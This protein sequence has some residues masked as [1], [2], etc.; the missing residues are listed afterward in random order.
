M[1]IFKSDDGTL[2]TCIED[3]GL[4]S[5]RSLVAYSP[6]KGEL[7]KC[8]LA[9]KD[10][11]LE[12]G[13]WVVNP[14]IAKYLTPAHELLLRSSI[15]TCFSSNYS[16]SVCLP[17]LDQLPKLPEPQLGLPLEPLPEPKLKVE[18]L[19]P[20]RRMGLMFR[21]D[22]EAWYCSNHLPAIRILTHCNMAGCNTQVTNADREA[23]GL[24]EEARNA[25]VLRPMRKTEPS[26]LPVKPIQITSTFCSLEGCLNE[27]AGNSK[28]CSRSCSNKNA[29]RAAA[30]RKKSL[31]KTG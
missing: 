12:A 28:Y 25:P 8:S 29:R 4:G 10:T 18:R 13:S 30:L 6:S 26:P 16:L 22:K 19:K 27:S 14:A 21:P 15:A 23:A 1:I 24:I 3:K 20:F 5:L 17:R 9:G 11:P 31:N 7:A 2:A